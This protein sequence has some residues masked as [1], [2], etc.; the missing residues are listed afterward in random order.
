MNIT[1]NQEG[2]TLTIRLDNRLDTITAPLLDAELKNSLDGVETLIWDFSS[3]EYLTSAG[4]RTLMNAQRTMLGKG[5]GTMKILHANETVKGVFELT[6][7]DDM[8]AE[9]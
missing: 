9:E 2:T 4:L 5:N 6:G 3:L 8:L 7:L 1:K